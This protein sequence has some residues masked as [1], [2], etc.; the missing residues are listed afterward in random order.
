MLLILIAC[1]VLLTL[2]YLEVQRVRLNNRFKH[3]AGPSQLPIIGSVYSIRPNNLTD[4][5]A[6]FDDLAVD[7]VA[8]FI[9]GGS[10]LLL[11]TDPVVLSQILPSKSFLE[12]PYFFDF[13]EYPTAMLSAKFKL[14]KPMRKQTNLAFNQRQINSMFPVFNKHVNILLQ[15]IA[16]KVDGPTFDINQLTLRMGSAQVMENLM[17][18]ADI[19][20]EIDTDLFEL[21]EDQVTERM[22]NPLY[23]PWV[24]YRTSYMYQIQD[25][26][27]KALH[28]FFGR[29]VDRKMNEIKKIGKEPDGKL[30]LD[31]MFRFE[32]EGKKLSYIELV[33]NIGLMFLAAYETS[34]ITISYACLMLAMHPEIDEKLF[35]E[36][37]ENYKIGEDID[38][39]MLKNFPY[40][41]MVVKETLRHFPAVAMSARQGM[42]D[43]NIEPLG[44]LPKGTIIVLNFWKLHR[45]PQFWGPNVEKFYPDH[46]LPENAAQRHPYA[47]LPFS[48]GPR[49]CVGMNYAL[50]T[51][52][53]ALIKILAEYRFTTKLKMED[54][55]FKISVTLKLANRHMVQ[56]H[57]R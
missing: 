35:A 52:K 28:E 54:L 5:K 16:A 31:E 22:V 23:Q 12:R 7:P 36:I 20:E 2:V 25:K 13:F 44:V 48:G 29:V 46:F 41:D 45:W 30:F 24:V 57:R 53:V 49:N 38:F 32:H 10:L 15:R 1:V 43:C 33:E 19:Q 50:Q 39:D 6:V 21:Y 9:F 11:V 3:V 17:G 18:Y 47:Y 4:F 8:K 56:V 42:E 40:L 37:Q 51:I 26:G 34:A 14:W 55:N 27:R